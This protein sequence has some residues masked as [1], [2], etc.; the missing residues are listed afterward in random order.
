[1]PGGVARTSTFALTNAT[2]PYVMALADKG[3]RK[4]L[5]DD[6]HFREGLNV[7]HGKVTHKAVAEALGYEYT[8]SQE[9]LKPWWQH[10]ED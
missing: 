10:P 4:A 6:A 1:M 9:A 2:L 3:Y 5:L 8:A 7:H